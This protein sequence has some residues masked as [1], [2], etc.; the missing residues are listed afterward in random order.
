MEIVCVFSG[1]CLFSMVFWIWFDEL[2]V[3]SVWCL[4]ASAGFMI[5]CLDFD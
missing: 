5:C 2:L 1:V 4:V 3:F